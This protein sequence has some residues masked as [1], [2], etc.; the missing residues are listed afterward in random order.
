MGFQLY[1]GISLLTEYN[2]TTTSYFVYY[3]KVN[4]YDIYE[5]YYP[6]FSYEIDGNSYI[7]QTEKPVLFRIYKPEDEK[8]IKLL[9]NE[10]N[11]NYIIIKSKVIWNIF[12]AICG[13]LLTISITMFYIKYYLKYKDKR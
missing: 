9:Y 13:F 7:N 2:K 11:P 6:T 3:K 8:E 10:N 4:I 5:K 1:K 12:G